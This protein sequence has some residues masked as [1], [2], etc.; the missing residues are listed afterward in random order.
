[1]VI[2]E[3]KLDN[4][5]VKFGEI[6]RV[7]CQLEDQVVVDSVLR[8]EESRKSVHLNRSFLHQDRTAPLH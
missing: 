2:R 1:M 6:V 5:V 3:G 7:L 4:I 8:I